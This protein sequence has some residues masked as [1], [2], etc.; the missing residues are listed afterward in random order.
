MTAR[1]PSLEVRALTLEQEMAAWGQRFQATQR[2]MADRAREARVL[3]LRW[4]AAGHQGDFSTTLSKAAGIS[5]TTAWRLWRAGLALE[6]G[7]SAQADQTDLIE[8]ARALDKG[9]TVPEIDKA[10]AAGTLRDVTN[11]ADVGMVGRQMSADA[12]GL[13]ERVQQRLGLFG[14]DH[15]PPVERDELVFSAFLSISDETLRGIVSS[16]RRVT[17]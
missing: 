16:Y 3:H 8:A 2:S 7:V 9:V 10:I 5:R 11:L 12:A 4:L 13:R 14:L 15:L 17:E 1:V 6:A